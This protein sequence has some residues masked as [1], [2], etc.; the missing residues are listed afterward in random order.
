METRCGGRQFRQSSAMHFRN[1]KF[2]GTRIRP[3]ITGT[4]PLRGR[5][6]T[7]RYSEAIYVLHAF[8]K[9]SKRG[10][11]TPKRD[12]DLIHHRLAE[13]E[14]LHRKGNN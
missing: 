6:A 4:L 10:I 11:A 1:L 14:R 7:V 13:A 9:K 3:A 2:D 12:L 8:Q 5:W